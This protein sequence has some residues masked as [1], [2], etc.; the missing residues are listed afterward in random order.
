M[1]KKTQNI[2]TYTKGTLAAFLS[3]IEQSI[4]SFFALFSFCIIS[5]L[6][7]A[8]FQKKKKPLQSRPLTE[9]RAKFRCKMIHT[10]KRK[11]KKRKEM[12]CSKWD[13]KVNHK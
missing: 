4:A 7:F 3:H 9:N 12:D 13:N 5:C 6:D 11:E 1:Y 8:R 2:L 10:G